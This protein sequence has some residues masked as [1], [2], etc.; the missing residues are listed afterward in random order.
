MSTDPVTDNRESLTHNSIPEHL[1]AKVRDSGG[2][3]QLGEI[4]Y[5]HRA[6]D[7]FGN[8]LPDPPRFGDLLTPALDDLRVEDWHRLPPMG[9]K[10]TAR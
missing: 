2:N 8:P 9:D 4:K 10:T 1:V 3:I 7:S 5:L 6:R